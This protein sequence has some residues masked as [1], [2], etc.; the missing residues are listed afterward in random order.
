VLVRDDNQ[1]DA[2]GDDGIEPEKPN[3]P[4]PGRGRGWCSV[5][6]V[7]TGE[8]RTPRPED[9]LI[10]IY[11]RLSRYF[12]L[13][14]SRPYQRGDAVEPAEGLEPRSSASAR[15]HSDLCRPVAPLGDRWR[16]T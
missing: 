12:V 5:F 4:P 3:Q 7:E 14:P 16:W 1:D 8:G 11:Y 15:Q 9:S 2:D 10:E 13:A 6:V